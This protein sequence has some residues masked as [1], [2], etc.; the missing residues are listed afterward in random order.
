[1]DNAFIAKMIKRNGLAGSAGAPKSSRVQEL[2]AE[3]EDDSEVSA[4]V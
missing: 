1:V 3:E 4:R 2:D